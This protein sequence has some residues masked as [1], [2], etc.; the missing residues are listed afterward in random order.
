MLEERIVGFVLV[1][2]DIDFY[3]ESNYAIS[4]FFILNKYRKLGI[5]KEAAEKVFNRHKG[6]WE[7]KMHP[8]N[9]GSIAFWKKVVE[10]MS[11]GK[12]YEIEEGCKE[13]KYGDG[14]LGTVI[15]FETID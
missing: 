2:T 10:E 4:E 11:K 8:K 1:D 14:S 13:S 6:K 12:K 9:I 7:I 15:G 3:K 5:G